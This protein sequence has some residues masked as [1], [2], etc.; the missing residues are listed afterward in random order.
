MIISRLIVIEMG[1]I[2]DKSSRENQ[3]TFYVQ[4][5]GHLHHARTHARTHTDKYVT[6]IAFRR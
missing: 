1:D 3:N 6:L 5:P 2:L 4:L